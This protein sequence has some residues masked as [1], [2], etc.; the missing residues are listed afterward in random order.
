MGLG[1]KCGGGAAK[2]RGDGGAWGQVPD[3]AGCGK[4]S[5]PVG[6][7]VSKFNAGSTKGSAAGM[8]GALDA[9]G[10]TGDFV[11]SLL[12]RSAASASTASRFSCSCFPRRRLDRGTELRRNA[13]LLTAAICLSLF[14]GPFGPLLSAISNSQGSSSRRTQR[15]HFME[16]LSMLGLHFFRDAVHALQLLLNLP[17]AAPPGGGVDG[18]FDQSSLG[19]SG[20]E[21]AAS[22]ESDVCGSSLAGVAARMRRAGRSVASAGTAPPSPTSLGMAYDKSSE[23]SEADSISCASG[24]ISGGVVVS[25]LMDWLPMRA[26]RGEPLA[27]KF[28]DHETKSG[29]RRPE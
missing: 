17:S 22:A 15:K 29:A 9:A 14:H 2:F 27:T 11:E 6:R 1:M 20:V 10:N 8:G 19:E 7:Q 28:K 12:S 26:G 13:A 4:A 24:P 18:K 25:Q 23:R 21:L 3:R 5:V 16:P